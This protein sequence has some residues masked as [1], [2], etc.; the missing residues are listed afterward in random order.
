MKDALEINFPLVICKSLNDH[1]VFFNG[2]KMIF[3]TY[4]TIERKSMTSE[5]KINA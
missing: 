5:K 1:K 2:K 4:L 3:L